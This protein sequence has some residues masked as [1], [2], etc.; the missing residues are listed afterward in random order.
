[1]PND[2]DND[3]AQ[4]RNLTNNQTDYENAGQPGVFRSGSVEGFVK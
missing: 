4:I 1:M 2:S 3:I